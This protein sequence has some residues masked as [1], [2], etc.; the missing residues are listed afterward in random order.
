M[1]NTSTKGGVF[2]NAFIKNYSTQSIR[3]K[4][5]LLYVLNV[6]D[7]IFTIA[8]LRTGYFT[9]VNLLMSKVVKSIPVSIL[10][11]VILPG[12]LLYY[13]YRRLLTANSA[14]RKASNIGINISLTMYILVNL[15]HL[16]WVG[17]LSFY[18]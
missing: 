17:M 6:A 13:L 3:L 11:K 15:S 8:L 1:V 2:M 5:I 16:V 9:E 18:I 14:Q 4:F 10:L 7:I 12:L